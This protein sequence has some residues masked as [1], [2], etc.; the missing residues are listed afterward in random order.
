MTTTDPP[1]EAGEFRRL[2]DLVAGWRRPLLLTHARP[3]GDA[4][5]S[6]MAMR[7]VL[8][9][10]GNQPR[11][12][13][14]EPVPP[15]YAWLLEGD[16]LDQV[17]GSADAALA[18]ADGVIVLDTCAYTQLEPVADWLKNTSLPKIALDHHVTRD[19]LADE[20]LI[21]EQAAAACLIIL[22]WATAAG[23]KLDDRARLG[24]YVGIV[25]DTGWFRFANTDARAHQ[26]ASRLVGPG[27]SPAAVFEELH[28]RESAPRIRLLAA[29]LASMELHHQGSLAVMT[30][31]RQMLVNAG[32][33]ANDTEDVINHPLQIASVAASV[34]L[35]ENDDGVVRLSFRSKPPGHGR[36]DLDVA[37]L[38]ETFG[39]GGH[40]RAAG[41]RSSG[42]IEELRQQVIERMKEHS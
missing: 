15:R 8:R 35:V 16:P 33:S 3:D 40:R 31:T 10:L 26:A 2:A 29:A 34:L 18:E 25:T 17:A 6:L 11:A 5:G 23:W 21:D 41:A 24:L 32:A 36:P 9:G 42:A 30:V 38:A 14:Y 13:L 1:I 12:A 20:Y 7:S 4:L 22:D 27:V 39:G 19:P 28:Q 37:A